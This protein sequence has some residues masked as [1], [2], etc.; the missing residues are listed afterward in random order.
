MFF[1]PPIDYG[2]FL[3]CRLHPGPVQSF[4]QPQALFERRSDAF[5]ERIRD[6]KGRPGGSEFV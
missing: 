3:L 5:R 4:V 2:L 1:T 6:Q